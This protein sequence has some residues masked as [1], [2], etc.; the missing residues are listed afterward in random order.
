RYCVLMP[1]TARGG[2]ISRKIGSAND[3]RRLKGILSELKIPDGMAVIVRTAGSQRSKAEIRRDY[4]YLMRLWDEIRQTTLRSTAPCLI[5]EE[6]N[7]IKRSIRDLYSRDMDEV[8]VQGEAGYKTAKAFMRS[9]MPSHAK[10]VKQYKD[11]STPIFHHYQVEGQLEAMHSPTVQLKSGGYIVLNQTEALVAIDVNSGRATR[12]RH[13]EETALKTNREA[14]EEVA[15]QL[16][17]RDLAGLI[18]VDFIDMEDPRH[19]REVER[20]LKEAM[21][22]DRAR[23]QLGRVSPFGLLELSRQRLRPSLFESSTDICP[24]C[25]GTGHVRSVHSSALA[26]LRSL[27]EEGLRGRGGDIR[28]AVPIA[29]AL[30]LLNQFRSRLMEVEQRYGFTVTVEADDA[31]LSDDYR[32]DR[33][34]PAAQPA[35]DAE[36]DEEEPGR[37]RR[38][39]RRRR[40]AGEE[41]PAGEPT[42]TAEPDATVDEDVSDGREEAREAAG[43]SDDGKKGRRRRGRRGGRRR[44]RRRSEA[45]DSTD[46]ASPEAPAEAAVEQTPAA[47]DESGFGEAA[48]AEEAAAEGPKDEARETQRAGRRGRARKPRARSP[49]P[50]AAAEETGSEEAALAGEPAGEETAET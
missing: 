39:G 26:V 3:R 38:R 15:R 28:V 36:A 48:D 43:E 11:Q 4:E 13:I 37:K 21:R 14:A 47:T 30:H 16:R 42:R 34:T 17:L 33:E 40:K 18:V 23:I 27:E 12:E 29:V 24:R 8:W 49:G 2:G 44:S 1:N 35:R 6:A 20:K 25:G 45:P 31:L 50:Q 5:H 10:K 41:E 46:G 19:N 32:L 9:L 7:L 22:S